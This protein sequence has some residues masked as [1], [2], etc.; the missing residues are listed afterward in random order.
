MTVTVPT[1]EEIDS[2]VRTLDLTDYAD[3]GARHFTRAQM[4]AAP[5]EVLG[6]VCELY[7]GIHLILV[8]VRSIPFIPRKW[9]DALGIFIDVMGGLCPSAE[10]D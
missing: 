6:N 4:K 7:S 2:R 1:F 10:R 8:G 9:R 5:A 3:G